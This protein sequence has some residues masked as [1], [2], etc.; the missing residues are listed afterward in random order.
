MTRTAILV[1]LLT[2]ITLEPALAQQP[3]QLKPIGGKQQP[4][5]PQAPANGWTDRLMGELDQLKLD[6]VG[7]RLTAAA[8]TAV[9]ERV[10]AALDRAA[11]ME[12][13]LGT[14]NRNQWNRA[15]SDIE[16][17][18]AELHKVVTQNITGNPTVSQAL[19]RIS[20]ATQQLGLAVGA[21]DNTPGQQKRQIARLTASLAEQAVQ[22]RVQAVEVLG[23]AG[24]GAPLERELRQFAITAQKFNKDFQDG[25]NLE[26]AGKELVG[27]SKQ[28][29]D[30]AMAFAGI[31]TPP[32]IRYQIHRVAA[33][34]R[35]LVELLN[36][37]ANP[38]PGGGGLFP[39][40]PLPPVRPP[41]LSIL[42]VGADVGSLPRV[43]VYSDTRGTVAHSFYAYNRAV[44]R[45]G[46]RVA[47]ADLNGDG[48]PEVVTT[49]GGRGPA[50]IKVFDGRD[51]MP[52]LAFDA[53]DGKSADYGNFVAAADLT[54]DGRALVAIAPDEG[55]PPLVEVYD[56]AA[57]KL[58]TTVQAFPRNFTGGVRLAWGD[59]NG[60]G[61]PDLITASGPGDL[62][63]AVRVFDGTNFTR[64]L[65]EFLGVN[66]KYRGG[67]F[68][69]AADLTKN[70]KAEIVVG[71]DAGSRPLVRVFEG[72]RGKLIG[73]FEPF[74]NNFR[75]GVRVALGDP[76]D[77]A[78][79]K[80]ICAAGPGTKGT[81]IKILGPDGKPQGE[82][83]P[84]PGAPGGSF[85]GSR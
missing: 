85:V 61:A 39:P 13:V 12:K 6:L 51:M 50:R 45:G 20:Y 73:E 33:I 84:F 29:E 54:R 77:G 68:V 30:V 5:P 53:F 62:P 23:S 2:V 56:L 9:N 65:S 42:A 52:L 14:N 8:R 3:L 47:V 31:P 80:L 58:V 11:T 46:V 16:A 4:E 60:D 64:V 66:E 25:E 63:S 40:K 79:L 27:V 48:L 76:N 83:N 37:N 75:G 69:A 44:Q 35:R 49:T 18:T 72:G 81:P 82:L 15:L 28:W 78:K 1:A 17:T 74:A 38:N 19:S 55:G 70:N 22:L 67:L 57:G 36:P 24:L 34:H 26:R 10:D 7:V 43:V 41:R 71:L 32:Q 59:I 21:G